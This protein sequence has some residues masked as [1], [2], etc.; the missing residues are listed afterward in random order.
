MLLNARYITIYAYGCMH[1]LVVNRQHGM[2]VKLCGGKKHSR[3]IRV[4]AGWLNHFIHNISITNCWHFIEKAL[5][6]NTTISFGLDDDASVCSVRTSLTTYC[7]GQIVMM[8]GGK[9][10]HR[11]QKFRPQSLS[12]WLQQLSYHLIDILLIGFTCC[13]PFWDCCVN[14]WSKFISTMWLARF[15]LLLPLLSQRSCQ[16]S[17]SICVLVSMWRLV[18]GKL[19][20]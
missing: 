7:W 19:Q 15:T 6:S 17:N 10:K 12:T 14:W 2:E 4:I 13:Q 1:I 18:L 5:A 11:G 16:P 3:I 20:S 9:E 8:V